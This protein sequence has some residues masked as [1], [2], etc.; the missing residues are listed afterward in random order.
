[1]TEEC[2][3]CPRLI[4]TGVYAFNFGRFEQIVVCPRT[5]FAMLAWEAR[6]NPACFEPE[7]DY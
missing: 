7:G 3:N 6:V 5:G 4:E 1:M 2:I